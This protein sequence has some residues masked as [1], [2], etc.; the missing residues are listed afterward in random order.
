MHE[1]HVGGDAD[2]GLLADRDQAGIAGEQVPHL[3]H[4]DI[5]AQF[6]HVADQALAGPPG[7]RGDR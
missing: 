6:D 3:R 4:R 7:H 1:H 5:A 2:E